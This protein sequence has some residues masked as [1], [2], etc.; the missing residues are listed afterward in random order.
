MRSYAPASDMLTF[1]DVGALSGFPESRGIKVRVQ[2]TAAIPSRARA[3][4]L[5]LRQLERGR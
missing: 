4:D 5:A 1:G 3:A 2:S